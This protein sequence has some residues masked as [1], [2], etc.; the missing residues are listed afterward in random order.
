M[1][2]EMMMMMMM[3]MMM[4]NVS[5]GQIR[6]KLDYFSTSMCNEFGSQ[7]NQDSTKQST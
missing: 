4:I 2:N 1:A 3:M 5:L 7:E 6:R